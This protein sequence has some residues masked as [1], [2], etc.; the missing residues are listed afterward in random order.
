MIA[1]YAIMGT[2]LV[3]NG[4]LFIS[5]KER[6]YGY[7]LLFLSSSTFLCAF[8]DG[9]T[10]QYLWPNNPDLNSRLSN[11]NASI[12]GIFYLLFV[13]EALD[14]LEFSPILRK[15]FRNMMAAGIVFTLHNIFTPQ[16]NHAAFLN[17][18][19]LGAIMP[20][21]LFSI[22]KAIRK[23]IP[24]AV[25]LLIAEAFS[26]IGAT[27]FMLMLQ[28]VVTP[29]AFTFWSAHG[30]IVGEAL[31]LALALADRTNRAIEAQLAAQELALENERKAYEAREISTKAKNEFL[32]S[33]SHELRTPL[34]S[35]IGFTENLIDKQWISAP[36]QQQADT[37]L[38]AGR[39]LLRVIDDVLNLSLIDNNQVSV[40]EQIIK[41][42]ALFHK[43]Q[44]KYRLEAQSKGIQFQ[45]SPDDNLPYAIHTDPD[46]LQQILYQIIGNAIKFTDIGSVNVHV[47]FDKASSH[48]FFIIADTGI[49]IA[50]DQLDSL[51][52]PFTQADSSDSR[53]YRG[54]GVGLFI[55]KSFTQLLGGTLDVD[56]TRNVG[57][58]FLL[59]LP[60]Y[61]VSRE[62]AHEL[63]NK[64]VDNT[65]RTTPSLVGQVLY[66]EDN[67][68]NQN[69][70]KVL[71]EA[72]GANLDLVNNGKEAVDAVLA[73]LENQPYDLVL[74][75]IQMPFMDGV[76]ATKQ[77]Q[78]R[79]VTTPIV[80]FSASA[81][82]DT[83]Y[84][85]IGFHG[86][87]SKPVDKHKLYST[88]AEY[89]NQSDDHVISAAND[90]NVQLR[91]QVEPTAIKPD[92]DK[93]TLSEW[94]F[95]ERTELLADPDFV[96]LVES[97]ETR[98]PALLGECRQLKEKQCWDELQ[99]LI[100]QVKGVAGGYG[101]KD[102]TELA[103]QIESEI[104]NSDYANL[105]NLFAST[106]SYLLAV[107][108]LREN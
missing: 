11:V 99:K 92:I 59:T 53:R 55:A 30:G 6:H 37:V 25:Y 5:I 31:L 18:F 51:F 102:L 89:L 50:T 91:D 42:D 36:G 33:V 79:G 48:L 58:R 106:D 45:L 85:D 41:T 2:L 40:T 105:D 90:A 57:S 34:T 81:M 95:S 64:S 3:Y 68:D 100:H 52:E 62:S 35:I 73:H 72:T 12:W 9:S 20:L 104:K 19:Y 98:L 23:K 60:C 65:L 26:I 16:L 29:N 63:A 67:E 82:K 71:V 22:I 21:T 83:A 38:R 44:T 8:I 24:S 94:D 49:G 70:V 66:A 17:Q 15:I 43:L 13:W 103:R 14:R 84:E 4:C 54:T 87:I 108:K 61:S 46:H 101:H 75:D 39:E 56:S 47:S 28:E 86:F 88:L 69:L 10:L 93:T 107:Q 76:T 27:I 78:A 74:M 1:F 7:Y 97:F 80:A 32:A 96:P 77:L